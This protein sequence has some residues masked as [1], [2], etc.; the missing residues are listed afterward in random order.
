MVPV[1][2]LES[3][4]RQQYYQV[5]LNDRGQFIGKRPFKKKLLVYYPTREC[6]IVQIVNKMMRDGMPSTKPTT[7]PACR[8][9]ALSG[10]AVGPCVLKKA[11]KNVQQPRKTIEE[12][13]PETT[14][15]RARP[16][17]I[18]VADDAKPPNFVWINPQTSDTD[19]IVITNGVVQSQ[20]AK[21]LQSPVN[22]SLENAGDRY[23]LQNH[24]IS[25]TTACTISL[26]TPEDY[27]NTPREVFKAD[28]GS[29]TLNNHN[30]LESITVNS[31]ILELQKFIESPESNDG[32]DATLDAS[33]ALSTQMSLFDFNEANVLD[34]A[35]PSSSVIKNAVLFS[36]KLLERQVQSHLPQYGLLGILNPNIP[37]DF[38]EAR[39]SQVYLNTNIPFSAFICGVQGSG[40]SHTLSCLIE[41][42]IIQSPALGL[43]EKPLS[44]L[45][46]HFEECS[47]RL[48]FRPS[49]AAFLAFPRI[50]LANP[51]NIR[52]RILVS[53]SNY[54]IL[55][56]L[57]KQIPG[58]MVQPFKLRPGDLNIAT[59]LTL[60]AVDQTES[61]PLYMSQVTRILREMAS[62]SPGKFDYLTFR[63]RLYGAG[64][65]RKQIEFLK[66]RLDL[67]ESFMDL[68]GST[69]PPEF[70]AGVVTIID[71]SC[72]FVDVNTACV[73][74]KIG[75]DMYLESGSEVGKIIAVDEAHK[76]MT[77][78][79]AAKALTESLLTVI[80]QQRHY[81]ARVI[82]STQEPTISPR[83]IDLCSITIIHRFSSPQW[84]RVLCQHISIESGAEGVTQLLF[85]RILSLGTGE[86]LI[87]APSAVVADVDESMTTLT[88]GLLKLKMRKRVTWDG[89]KSVVCL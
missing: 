66:Q 14:E 3:W 56:A 69:I 63:R 31:K 9:L 43:L 30:F 74:F 54:L 17:A 38:E 29:S 51:I 52:V 75:M 39:N 32:E 37:I 84:F 60:M 2:N 50:P 64:L 81:G 85:K 62:Q 67:L 82:I 13:K 48:S 41:N 7:P 26:Q 20:P 89:G 79:P 42:C 46:F 73:M 15:S 55:S 27:P 4:I 36:K 19:I 18:H 49:E 68:D 45:V 11:T 58:V 16:T 83:L 34:K 72:P 59:M 77:D 1:S 21:L 87:F 57:Y 22:R 5:G 8:K 28:G 78:T 61:V 71:M 10:L 47:S 53:P 76:Y 6:E 65:D 70:E 44:A 40:K 88:D 35:D 80:R 23:V 12:H 86:A 33:H 24:I 25:S